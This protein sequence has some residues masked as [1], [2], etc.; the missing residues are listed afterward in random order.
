MNPFEFLPLT[1][2]VDQVGSHSYQSLLDKYD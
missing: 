1:F 2:Y